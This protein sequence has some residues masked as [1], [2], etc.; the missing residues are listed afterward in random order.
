MLFRATAATLLNEANLWNADA[1]E[2]QLA[3]VENNDVRRA[4]TR[5]EHWDERV[6]M[7]SWWADNLDRL[8]AVG[9]VVRI[10]RKHV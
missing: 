10:R 9:Q 5:G 2:R 6:R 7:M 1:I 8:K 4:Y 3:H